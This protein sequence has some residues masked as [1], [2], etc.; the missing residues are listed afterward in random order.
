MG[1]WI[2]GLTVWVG[3]LRGKGLLG[4]SVWIVQRTAVEIVGNSLIPRCVFEGTTF[5]GD[6]EE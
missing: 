6:G 4:Y 1:R 2:D 5:A 3:W